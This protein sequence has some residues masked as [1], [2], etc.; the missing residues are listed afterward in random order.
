MLTLLYLTATLLATPPEPFVIN[1]PEVIVSI[2]PSTHD[3]YQLLTRKTPD[4]YTCSAVVRDA[5][6]RAVVMRSELVLLPNQ[7][8][9][10]VRK[11]GDYTLEFAVTMKTK[12][13]HAEVTVKRGDKVLTR[14]RSTVS[15]D[16][17]PPIKP[18]R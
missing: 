7:S 14:Q 3:E 4:T 8:D 10:E 5:E 1:A 12:S 11:F 13:A 18:A 6:V 16:S 15:L 2:A 17:D 9:R